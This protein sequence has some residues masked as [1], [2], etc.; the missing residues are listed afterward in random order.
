MREGLT[1]DR[2]KLRKMGHR[3]KCFCA[4]ERE[5]KR[6]GKRKEGMGD[7]WKGRIGKCVFPNAIV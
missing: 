4:Y 3:K 2:M 7:E 1:Q 6:G 5:K